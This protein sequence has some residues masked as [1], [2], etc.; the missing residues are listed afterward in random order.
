MTA[1]DYADGTR[2]GKR[3]PNK[4]LLFKHCNVR[5]ICDLQTHGVEL[6]V[7]LTAT[8][9]P[10]CVLQYIFPQGTHILEM[11]SIIKKKSVFHHNC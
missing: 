4:K 8:L 9:L 3:L 1:S 5:A 10:M 11:H 7:H 2:L 6:Q